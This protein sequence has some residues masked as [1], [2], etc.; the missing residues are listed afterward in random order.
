MSVQGLGPLT[1]YRAYIRVPGH[2]VWVPAEGN[3][4]FRWV[5]RFLPGLR[6]TFKVWVPPSPWSTPIET[7][8][9]TA[10]FHALLPDQ[11]YEFKVEG[12]VEEQ[13]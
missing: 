10:T 8:G 12:K 6:P 13:A 9:H 1:I 5:W 2:Y 7:D 11:N 3:R 4:F